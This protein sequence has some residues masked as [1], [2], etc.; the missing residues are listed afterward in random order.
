MSNFQKNHYL[1][2]KQA[3]NKEL[4]NFLY[5]YFSIK[6]DVAYTVLHSGFVSPYT[7]YFGHWNDSQ[8]PGSFSHYADIAM[9]TLLLKVQP[10]M[11]Q[12]TKIKLI[13][14]YSYTRM[15]AKGNE[16]KRHKDRSS[17]EISTTMNLGGDL[18][19][20]FIKLSNKKNIQVILEPGDMLVYKGCILEHWREPFQGDECCQVFLH[21]N[22]ALSDFAEENKYDKRPHLGLPPW[23]KD[24]KFKK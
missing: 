8:V 21:Y 22:N 1:V 20:I 12:H 15:Y 7:E 24:A 23:F 10:I 14:T 5:N 3:I 11:E 9:D 13:P 6:K 17:C 4:A 16:L 18:W 19:P 2:I